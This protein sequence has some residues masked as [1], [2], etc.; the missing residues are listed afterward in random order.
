M[1]PE[2]GGEAGECCKSYSNPLAH[3]LNPGGELWR[4]EGRDTDILVRKYS[5]VGGGV[6]TKRLRRLGVQAPR[7]VTS[8]GPWQRRGS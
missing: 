6:A 1:S 7:P 8:V 5:R 2:G 4:W 3:M